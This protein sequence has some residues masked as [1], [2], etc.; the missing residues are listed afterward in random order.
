MGMV[1]GLWCEQNK[2]GH[3]LVTYGHE[4]AAKTDVGAQSLSNPGGFPEDS[5]KPG[6]IRESAHARVKPGA[7]AR[8]THTLACG[9]S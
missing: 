4:D 3:W 9:C 7:A 8:W 6:R 1:R 5:H 2:Y